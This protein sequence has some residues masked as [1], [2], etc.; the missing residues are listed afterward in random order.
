MRTIF[1]AGVT[2]L[3]L[4]GVSTAEMSITEE[5]ILAACAS[6][7]TAADRTRDGWITRPEA[8]SAFVAH[9]E[10]L[11][12]DADGAV[13]QAEFIGC[14]AGSGMRTTTRRVTTLRSN[15]PFFSADSDGDSALS[16]AE[17][18]VTAERL[19]ATLPTTDGFANPATYD[20]AMAGFSLPAA[21]IDANGDGRIDA[22]EAADG[23]LRGHRAADA[24]HDGLVSMPEFGNR[25]GTV[26]V[27]QAG[28]D[29]AAMAGRMAELFRRLDADGD[30]AISLQEYRA[31]GEARFAAAAVAGASD[32]EIAIPVDAL[33]RLPPP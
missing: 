11:D 1:L 16:A 24:D 6:G 13:T 27:E 20:A 5:T 26:I 21:Q 3:A 28:I 30:G 23:R 22:V 12:G 19:A 2:A 7:L 15:H 17:W 18:S 4:H 8:E 14:R 29:A 9:Y 33:D 31:A 25:D 10:L 32:P